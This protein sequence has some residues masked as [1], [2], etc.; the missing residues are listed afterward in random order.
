MK[1]EKSGNHKI[2]YQSLLLSTTV[3]NDIVFCYFKSNEYM[4]QILT[5]SGKPIPTLI[6]YTTEHAYLSYVTK[7]VKTGLTQF[8]ELEIT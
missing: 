1:Y 2:S 4:Q 5:L 8:Y 3:L 7:S 6:N